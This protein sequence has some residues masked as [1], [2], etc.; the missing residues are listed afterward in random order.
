[1]GE[2]LIRENGIEGRWK[3][4]LVQLWNGDQI[5][6]VGGD[7]IMERIGEN[8]RIVREMVREELMGTVQ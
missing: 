3:E 4:Y 7:I 2:E 5:R 1:M 8:E 6:E